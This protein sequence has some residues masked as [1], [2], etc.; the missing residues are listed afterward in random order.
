MLSDSRGRLL[1]G[2]G[3]TA[4][5]TPA[6]DPTLRVTGNAGCCEIVRAERRVVGRGF[7][8]H[9]GAPLLC[10]VDGPRGYVPVVP[11]P[12][13]VSA[14]VIVLRLLSMSRDR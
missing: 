12:Q 2:G 4:T 7:P 10:C 14:E 8:A 9:A 1:S 3:T 6:N 5:K 13:K 11:L